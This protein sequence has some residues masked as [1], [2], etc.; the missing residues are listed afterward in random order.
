ME[1]KMPASHISKLSCP[2][3]RVL[4]FVRSSFPQAVRQCLAV[5]AVI[6]AANGLINGNQTANALTIPVQVETVPPASTIQNENAT[7]NATQGTA[8]NESPESSMAFQS[9]TDDDPKKPLDDGEPQSKK[10]DDADKA[11]TPPRPFDGDA[12]WRHLVAVCQI[13]PRISTSNGMKLQQKYL[14]QH[15]ESIGGKVLSQ[16]FQAT[17]PFNNRAVALQNM[18]VQFHPDRKRRLL[19]C[20]H[21][22]TRPFADRD[23]RNPRAKFIGANDGGS[24]VALLSELGT[25]LKE[26]QGPYG[27]DLVFF[28]G[29]E[30]VIDSRVHPMFLGSTFFAQQYANNQIPWRYEWG[31]LVDMVADKDLQIYYEANSLAPGP[32]RLTRSIWGVAQRLGIREFIPQKKHIV[33]DDHLPLN[34]IAGIPTCDIIDFDFPNPRMGNAYWHTTND[35]LRNCSKE[36]LRKV[37][38]VVLTWIREMQTIQNQGQSSQQKSATSGQGG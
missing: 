36:S 25:H 7:K 16:Q 18:I 3:F 8:E 5:F 10:N 20:C 26:M 31:I 37:G 13:G 17:S 24:G 11:K 22:D 9:A 27:V 12:A 30:F 21:Y 14:K 23:K 38:L 32:D 19:I 35:N 1:T 34:N 28:D 4:E 33:K 2:T 6:L 15:F 29:E